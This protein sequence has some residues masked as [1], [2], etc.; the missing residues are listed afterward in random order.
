MCRGDHGLAGAGSA[1]PM[2]GMARIW[3]FRPSLTPQLGAVTAFAPM[4]YA[5]GAP[6]CDDRARYHVLP[7]FPA[8][9]LPLYGSASRVCRPPK[10]TTLQLAGEGRRITFRWSG[11]RAGLRAFLQPVI[12]SRP[13]RS[14]S[15][16]ARR[17]WRRPTSRPWPIPRPALKPHST[18]GGA[19]WFGGLSERGKSFEFNGL[20]PAL[21][22]VAPAKNGTAGGWWRM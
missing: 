3:F 5:N 15:C 8:G 18:N 9:D 7:R 4:I 1:A 20:V 10:T 19:N 13:I 12:V 22:F 16:R 14:A 11:S 6:V 2:S 21:P 17:R